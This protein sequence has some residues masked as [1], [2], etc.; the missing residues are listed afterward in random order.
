MS[1][2]LFRMVFLS[3]GGIAAIDG[4]ETSMADWVKVCLGVPNDD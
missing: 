2:Q 3:V 4:G 1:S